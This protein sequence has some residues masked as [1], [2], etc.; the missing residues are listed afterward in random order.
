MDSNPSERAIHLG[1]PSYVWRAGQERRL[2]ILGEYV[3]LAQ[4]RILDI[5]CGLGMYTEAFQ[6]YSPHVY[7]IEVELP[8]AVQAIPRA[9]GVVQAVGETIPFADNFFDVV[10]S[11]EVL[12]HVANDRQVV[13]EAVRVTKPG[14][15]IAIFV[16]NRLWPW[17]THG[18]YWRGQYH[19]GNIPLVNYLPDGWRSRLAWHVRV[20]TKHSL[21]A[22]FHSL[23][24]Q[25]LVHRTVYPG[26]DNIIQRSPGLGRLIRTASYRCE[27]LP[28]L[29]QFG[30]SHLVI[31][32]K[33]V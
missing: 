2:S 17:E 23:P 6:R 28:V 4:R 12:E 10:F 9:M 21:L 5:G 26:F 11:H 1:H 16:P 22:L 25:V 33:T 15:R 19:F 29:S 8:R 31:V 18:V 20:Y 32:E 14:G 27:Q 30:L 3:D 24:V 7:G 13:C